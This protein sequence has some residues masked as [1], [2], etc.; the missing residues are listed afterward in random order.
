MGG[1]ERHGAAPRRPRTADSGPGKSRAT[2]AGR[3]KISYRTGA[4]V[5]PVQSVI[6]SL[7]AAG[8]CPRIHVNAIH[9]DVVCP[10]FIREQWKERLIIDLDA[11]YPLDLSFEDH[12]ISADLSFGGYVTRC[13]FPWDAIYVV[14]DRAT[15]RG[16]VLDRNMPESIRRLRDANADPAGARG[17][18]L[19]SVS[20]PDSGKPSVVK[21]QAVPEPASEVEVSE[22]AEEAAPEPSE[23]IRAPTRETP[24]PDTPADTQAKKRRAAF[25]VIDGGG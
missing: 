6:E 3:G 4:M 22:P 18:A 16:N 24:A 14:A 10:K 19:R 9:A 17:A 5:H 15:G 12:G 7:Y 20:L 13:S 8:R 21:P 11:N 1:R 2:L 23:S 25:K